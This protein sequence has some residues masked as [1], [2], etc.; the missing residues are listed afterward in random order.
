M[1]CQGESNQSKICALGFEAR[2]LTDPVIG[3]SIEPNTVHMYL[4]TTHQR[5]P[6]PPFRNAGTVLSAMLHECSSPRPRVRLFALQALES[7]INKAAQAVVTATNADAPVVGAVAEP[8]PAV[9]ALLLLNWDHNF[10][11]GGCGGREG[12]WIRC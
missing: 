5:R 6:P 1:P 2:R 10:K 9:A 8:L 3:P 7:W 11:M 4:Q 12:V